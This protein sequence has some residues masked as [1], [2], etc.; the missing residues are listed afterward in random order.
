[1]E[2]NHLTQLSATLAAHADRSSTT[3]AKWCGV[4]SRLFA[5]L[6]KGGGCRVDTDNETLR[7]FSARWPEDLEW[8]R[9]MEK[10]PDKPIIRDESQITH[11]HGRW[12]QGATNG[13]V[14]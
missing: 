10:I 3:I 12:R 14:S 1:M 5:R 7:A 6:C 2:T 9:S 8:P 11:S 4:H 13:S